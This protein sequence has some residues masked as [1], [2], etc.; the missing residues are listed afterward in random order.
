MVSTIYLGYYNP[1]KVLESMSIS[2]S[3]RLTL[4]IKDPNIT[5]DA[6]Y[7]HELKI[8]GVLSLVITQNFHHLLQVLVRIV[9]LS[10]NPSQS[11]KTD[12]KLSPLKCREYPIEEHFFVSKSNATFANTVIILF[13]IKHHLLNIAI[14]YQ[15]IPIWPA[16]LM[17]RIK[18]R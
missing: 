12:Q 8:K 5:F 13:P 3:I 17:P 14:L 2:N 7:V 18:Y 11:S 10:I 9:V 1:R 15:R 16:F 4:N 6:N